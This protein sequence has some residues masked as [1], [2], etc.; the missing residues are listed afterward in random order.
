MIGTGAARAQAPADLEAVDARQHHVEH[1]EVEGAL[2]EARERLAAVGRLHDLVAVLAQRDRRAASGST[3]RRRRA[4]CGGRDRP[5]WCTTTG[6]ASLR[7][8]LHAR[9]ADLP[10]GADPGPLRAHRRARSR[11]RTARGPVGTTLAPDAF[12]GERARP[13]DLDGLARAY[14]DRRPGRRGD[15]RA[16]RARWRSTFRAHRAATGCASGRSRG[17]T[18]DGKRELTTSSPRAR[19]ASPA[20]ARRRRAPRRGRA[21]ARAAELSGTAALLELA[22]V[23]AAARLQRTITLRLDERRQRRRGGR[24]RAR[25][26]GCG[27][28]PTRCSCSATSRRRHG[29]PAVRAGW[30]TRRRRRP[31]CACAARVR[32]RGARGDRRADPGGARARASG[33]ASPS[34]LTLGEQGALVAARPAGGA[35]VGQRRAPAAGRRRRSSR[36]RAAGLR[37]RRAAHGHRARRRAADCASPRRPRRARDRCRKVLPRWAVRLLVGALLLAPLRRGGRRLRAR[38][39]GARRRSLPW[40]GWL[41]ARGRGAVRRSR[42]LRLVPGRSSA[43]S[44]RRRPSPRRPGAI[45]LRGGR[46]RRRWSPIAARRRAGW[47]SCCARRSRAPRA[48]RG[49]LRAAGRRAPRCC[50][51]WSRRCCAL[52]VAAQP[53]RGGA[54]RARRAPLAC[55]SWRPACACAAPVAVLLAVLAALPPVAAAGRDRPPLGLRR[56]RLRVGGPAVGGRRR[57]RPAGL[58]A[59][60]RGRRVPARG[61][62]A[63]A[64]PAGARARAR[65][66]GRRA[67]VGPR[68]RRLRRAGLARRHR[69]GAAM[70][71]RVLGDR[72]RAS[73]ACCGWPTRRSRSPG[74]SRSAPCASA[75][76]SA[77]CDASCTR[78]ACPRPR[79]AAWARAA[80]TVA[81]VARARSRTGDAT[82]GRLGELRI[83]RI[84]LRRRRAHQRAP[85]GPARGPGLVAPSTV[86]GRGA[87]P[88]SPATARPTA[89][90]SATST[91]CAAATRSSSRCPTR[92]SAT[93]SR[94]GGS[95]T[96]RR[97]R[98]VADRG[99][100]RLVLTACHPLYSAARR[101]V[102]VARLT[103]VQRSA[104][105]LKT[106]ASDAR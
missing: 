13:A 50:S 82:A 71:R 86:P 73:P 29:A 61:A 4:G 16:R 81:A 34:R 74:R 49:S 32:G 9:P 14:A 35:A 77:S 27:E 41:G 31:R 11:S 28:P 90:R 19:S 42:C 103:A 80:P 91:S 87:R 76:P 92:R 3:A 22:R 48:S 63:G 55:R 40:L 95:S 33:R 1:D 24:A 57:R 8:G 85:A 54:A 58:A 83:P 30:S 100:D 97:R 101:I 43:C 18:I 94:R 98:A 70:T 62:A 26:R 44:R 45:P 2:G 20:R 99:R 69:V 39:A 56:G 64:A 79:C 46:R 106:S 89:R 12:D 68:S 93:P 10:G 53:V 67:P 105:E 66:D 72:A 102:V 25:R 104:S 84:G 6:Y 7:C 51:C 21:A 17:E 36:G 78:C 38:C 75:A 88:R 59:V 52:R 60:E 65:A 37:P 23:F 96:P 15:E 47:R 5:S